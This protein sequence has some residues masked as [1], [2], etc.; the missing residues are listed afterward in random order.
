VWV[1]VWFSSRLYYPF[2]KG[3]GQHIYRCLENKKCENE[4][5]EPG[6]PRFCDIWAGP[7]PPDPEKGEFQNLCGMKLH[8]GV[9]PHFRQGELPNLLWMKWDMFGFQQK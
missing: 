3:P 7:V 2:G 1:G 8:D 9:C 4:N 6:Q 5:V